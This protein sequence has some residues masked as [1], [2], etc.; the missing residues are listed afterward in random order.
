V[1]GVYAK[2]DLPE[3]HILTDDDVY[4]AVPLQKTQL[5]CRELMRGQVV[6]K[7]CL[8]DA[9]LTIDTVDTPYAY[10]EAMRDLITKRGL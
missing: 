5:S 10:N 8:A 6:I 7:P 1:R 4:L 2:R 3:G 9:P